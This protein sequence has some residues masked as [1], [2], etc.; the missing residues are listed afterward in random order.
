MFMTGCVVLVISDISNNV[1]FA[2]K[3]H[4]WANDTY[5]TSFIFRTCVMSWSWRCHVSLM[6]TPSSKVL[7]SVHID[8]DFTLILASLSQNNWLHLI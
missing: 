8:F 7:P 4:N 2:W 5:K 3:C 1:I 6:H